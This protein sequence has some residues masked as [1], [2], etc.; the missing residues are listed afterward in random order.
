MEGP[1]S[2]HTHR[3]VLLPGNL[4][5]TRTNL[6]CFVCIGALVMTHLI[7]MAVLVGSL[8]S[9]APEIKTTLDDVRLMVPQMHKTLSELGVM[10]PE[11]RTGMKIL[12]Q[13]CSSDSQCHV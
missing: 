7:M 10:I 4:P 9:V 6:G 12:Q 2:L 5:V 13:L 1:D 11:I 8:S 3:Q